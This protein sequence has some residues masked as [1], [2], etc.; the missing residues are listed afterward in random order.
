[1]PC[2][3]RELR[4]RCLPLA[5]AGVLCCVTVAQKDQQSEMVRTSY[6]PGIDFSKYHTYKWV[7]I[8][9]QH[10]PDPSVDAQIKQ[11]IDSQLAAKGLTEAADTADLDV[12]YQT[13]MS[14]TEKWESY[15]DWSDPSIM[16]QRI[17]EQ[18]K[19]MIEVG[20]LVVDMYETAGKKLVWTGRAH[21]TL[22]PK[23]SREERQKNLDKAAKK[24]LANFPPK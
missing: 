10:H 22:D 17:G 1:M 13:A 3:L 23:S 19:V 7:E 4:K 20:T 24:L 18:R 6:A 21:K 15:E 8:K 11:S 2:G 5:L 12:D 14:K 9:G 16:G